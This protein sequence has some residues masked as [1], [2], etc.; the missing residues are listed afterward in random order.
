MS[1]NITSEHKEALKRLSQK[2]HHMTPEQV[3]EHLFAN[4][5][6]S[7]EERQKIT[8]SAIVTEQNKA[9]LNILENKKEW[10]YQCLLDG[11]E[12]TG[13]KYAIEILSGGIYNVVFLNNR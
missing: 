4:K 8:S 9:L 12:R 10:M 7:L 1:G 11:L 13:Q 5:A 3:T 2:Q 6:L